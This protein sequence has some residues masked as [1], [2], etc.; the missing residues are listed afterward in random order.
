MMALT[1]CHSILNVVHLGCDVVLCEGKVY[2]VE[3]W[4]S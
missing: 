3:C 4:V 2:D 1:L